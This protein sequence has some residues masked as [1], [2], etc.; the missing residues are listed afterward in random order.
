MSGKRGIPMRE[1]DAFQNRLV[2]K[3]IAI[4]AGAVVVLSD[5]A[6]RVLNQLKK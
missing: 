6:G 5:S 3:D 1:R 2:I 4:L